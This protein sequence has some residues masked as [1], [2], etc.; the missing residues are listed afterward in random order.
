MDL[1]AALG[2]GIDHVA[3]YVGNYAVTCLIPIFLLAGAIVVYP[4]QSGLFHYFT[5]EVP[6]PVSYLTALGTGMILCIFTLVI[7]PMFAA[8]HRREAAVGPQIVFLYAG[9]ALNLIAVFGIGQLYGV[10][11]AVL[12]IGAATGVAILTALCMSALFQRVQ[13]V[14]C[15]CRKSAPGKWE[16]TLWCVPGLFALLILLLLSGALPV[17]SG[18]KF[19]L[20]AGIGVV[21]LGYTTVFLSLE[22]IREWLRSAGHIAVR[23][24]PFLL[25]GHFVLGIFTSVVDPAYIVPYLSD[26]SL[27]SCLSGAVS[28]LFYHMPAALDVPVLESTFGPDASSLAAGPLLALILAGSGICLPLLM[29]V[30]VVIG[31]RR[32]LV[33]GGLV[34]VF[35]TLFGFF[36]GMVSGPLQL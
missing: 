11:G 21:L 5:N 26:N 9:S 13:P 18:V 8:L 31:T 6:R 32:A 28:G 30:H 36:Y 29:V 35:A 3:V 2:S 34:I 22:S 4:R 10:S 33:Y 1:S 24:V 12:L 7:I 27:L 20:F 16:Q 17:S 23:A 15:F 14:G 25:L 19:L